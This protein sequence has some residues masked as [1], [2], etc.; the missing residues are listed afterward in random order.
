MSRRKFGEFGESLSEKRK[1]QV[2][3]WG[4]I[5]FREGE[6]GSQFIIYAN[7]FNDSKAPPL[8]LFPLDQ[9]Q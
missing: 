5:Y 4:T 3:L 7:Y 1:Q 2:L 8:A 9:L 6:G